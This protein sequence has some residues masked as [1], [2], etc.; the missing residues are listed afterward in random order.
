MN[1]ILSPSLMCAD[2]L[3]IESEVKKLDKLGVEYVHLDF[4]D[5]KF[6]PNITLDTTLIRLVK[7]VLVNMKRDIHIMAYEPESFFDK[8]E[9]GSGDIVSIHIE[10]FSETSE[11]HSA[12]SNIK[13][14]GAKPFLA[15]SPDT[16]LESLNAFLDEIDGILVMTVYP[17]FAGQPIVEGSFDRIKAVRKLIASSGKDLIL[18]VDGHVSWDLCSKMRECGG[19]MFVAGSSSVYSKGMAL[20][21]AVTKMKELIK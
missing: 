13:S 16:P 20:D 19:D 7:S 10:A 21:V 6:V 3:N 17:G 2:M 8:M 9:I 11:L 1:G 5:N 12:L 4:M 14:R 18:E 15:I